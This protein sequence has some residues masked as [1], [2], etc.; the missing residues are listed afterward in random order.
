[1]LSFKLHIRIGEQDLLLPVAGH[2]VFTT[3]AGQGWLAGQKPSLDATL[4]LAAATYCG[5]AYASQFF[6]F[7]SHWLGVTKPAVLWTKTWIA[8]VAKPRISTLSQL[9]APQTAFFGD[10]A[11]PLRLGAGDA[12]RPRSPKTDLPS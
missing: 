12:E 3:V 11:P 8:V 10:C 5:N 2:I 6:A 1:M 7:S 4:R 9:Q